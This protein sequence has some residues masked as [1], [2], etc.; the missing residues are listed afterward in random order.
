MMNIKKECKCPK[1]GYKMPY[2][3]GVSCLNRKCSKCGALM[4]DAKR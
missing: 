1:C 3:E 2:Y 4:T